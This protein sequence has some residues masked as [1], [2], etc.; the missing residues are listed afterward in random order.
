MATFTNNIWVTGET[1]TADGLN[2]TKHAILEVQ[3]D[4]FEGDVPVPSFEIEIP[5]D[6]AAGT[7]AN[8]FE[9]ICHF[10]ENMGDSHTVVGASPYVTVWDGA[11]YYQ[12]TFRDSLMCYYYPE[13][14][15]L[16]TIEPGLDGGGPGLDG[17][18][19]VS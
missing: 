16:T 8:T 15:I 6:L 19:D 4:D 12:I 5:T 9:L 3:T 7:I 18:G 17:G 1:I 11:G 10:P 13:T 2:S 14:G